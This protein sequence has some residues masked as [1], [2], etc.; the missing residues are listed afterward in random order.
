MGTRSAQ[1]S[2]Q[3]SIQLFTLVIKRKTT[4]DSQRAVT[5]KISTQ[6][7]I[8]CAHTRIRKAS[9]TQILF[10]FTQNLFVFSLRLTVLSWGLYC[11]QDDND[12]KSILTYSSY[13]ICRIHDTVLGRHSQGYW[14][15]YFS[16]LWDQGQYLKSDI[17]DDLKTMC[18]AYLP[19]QFNVVE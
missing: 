8:V 16:L 1:R 5:E 11:F 14:P 19:I 2:M 9:F 13:R 12:I 7:G 4:T 18:Q 3:I 10:S 6:Q 17:P 15:R